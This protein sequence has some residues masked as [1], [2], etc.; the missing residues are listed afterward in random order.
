[1]LHI[2]TR[3]KPFY[4]QVPTKSKTVFRPWSQNGFSTMVLKPVFG[5]KSDQNANVGTTAPQK[6]PRRKKR[7]LFTALVAHGRIRSSRCYSTDGLWRPPSKGPITLAEARD[8]AIAS[9]GAS[10]LGRALPKPA[11][12][13]I[14]CRR[15]WPAPLGH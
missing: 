10:R 8:E 14:S 7:G 4:D 11:S 9:A 15:L 13:W 1:M 6:T 12:F 5:P 3:R 2:Q